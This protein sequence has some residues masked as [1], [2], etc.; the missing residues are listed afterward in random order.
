MLVGGFPCQDYSVA[1]TLASAKGIEG[2]KGVLW[3]EIYRI[4]STSKKPPKYLFLEN[5][6]RLVSHDE[7]RTFRTIIDTLVKKLGYYVIGVE[8]RED[9]SLSYNPKA[10]V[11]NSR[12]FG[13]PQNRPRT[14]IIGFDTERFSPERLAAL[15]HELPVARAQEIYH[16]LNDLLEHNVPAKYYMASGYNE[17]SPSDNEQIKAD[18]DDLYLAMNGMTLQDMDKIIYPLCT[19]CRAHEKTGFIEGIKLGLRIEQALSET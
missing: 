7:G 6:D 10:F 16:D 17:R 1:H 18:F 12:D 5:V 3:W 14:Y 15:P 2:K 19:L 9:G 8:R 13:V 4:L 11:R